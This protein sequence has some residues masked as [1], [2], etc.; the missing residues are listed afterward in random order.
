M[1]ID[2]AA[3]SA[4]F[5]E[6]LT[7][8]S[9]AIGSLFDDLAVA[10]R[11]LARQ[12]S[13]GD[14]ATRGYPVLR[15]YNGA[16]C[17]RVDTLGGPLLQAPKQAGIGEGVRTG[18]TDFV[19]G[20]G[21]TATAVEQ[22]LALPRLMVSIETMLAGAE[23]AIKRSGNPTHHSFYAGEKPLSE[24]IGT[25]VAAYS[26]FSSR[27]AS[28]Q[29]ILFAGRAG[30]ATAAPPGDEVWPAKPAA[31]AAADAKAGDSVV[32]L[33]AGAGRQLTDLALLLPLLGDIL[34]VEIEGRSP[35]LKQSVL[36]QL[37]SVEQSLNSLRGDAIR[38]LIE[39]CDLLA[40]VTPMTGAASQII[41]MDVRLLTGVH[42]RFIA[43]LVSDVHETMG[44]VVTW[45]TWVGDHFETLATAADLYLGGGIVEDMVKWLLADPGN[46]TARAEEY[47]TADERRERSEIALGMKDPATLSPES[48]ARILAVEQIESLV[49]YPAP[50]LPA[51]TTPPPQLFAFPNVHDTLFGLTGEFELAA[52]VYD[53]GNDLR[54]NVARAFVAG[55]TTVT[56]VGASIGEATAH[57]TATTLD[58]RRMHRMARDATRSAQIVFGTQLDELRAHAPAPDPLVRAYDRALKEV[59]LDAAMGDAFMLG[60]SAVPVYVGE[61]R[62]FW[63]SRQRVRDHPT[64]PHILARRA[65][66]AA[67]EIPRMTVRATGRAPDKRLA[68]LVAQRFH[69]AMGQAYVAGRAEFKRLGPH[70]RKHPRP[71]TSQ[72]AAA[73]SGGTAHGG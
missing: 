64:S 24:V 13:R 9:Q 61:M 50:P 57:V 39:R 18:A 35:G 59:G 23:G 6:A 70:G 37:G 20:I 21:W 3:I 26:T 51:D 60:G 4:Q 19:S 67:V 65:R 71:A 55:Q 34:A 38:D 72:R 32:T 28:D 12:A 49:Y 48:A 69:T 43:E 14:R 52:G 36:G 63:A 2:F 40:L 27:A 1:P 5:A 42:P 11:D 7:A 66:L 30:L 73:R 45:G 8:E 15:Y 58:G 25:L 68:E 47:L 44:G 62:A 17:V 53:L 41:L 29:L 10:V 54:R 33:L 16:L 22:E 31:D 56:Q 46:P